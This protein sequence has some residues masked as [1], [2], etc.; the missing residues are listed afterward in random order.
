MV[1]VVVT[2]VNVSEIKLRFELG[3]LGSETV[4]AVVV[5]AVAV[6]IIIGA[7]GVDVAAVVVDA[8]SVVT[9]AVTV[10]AVV[11]VDVAGGGRGVDVLRAAVTSTPITDPGIE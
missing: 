4:F 2:G 6:A 5:V 11:D 7:A 1:V 3:G 8:V 9:V 10:V